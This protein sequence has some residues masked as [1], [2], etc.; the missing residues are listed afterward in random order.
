MEQRA[1]TSISKFKAWRNWCEENKKSKF[2]VRKEALV[3]KIWYTRQERLLKQVFD[4]LKYSAV[5]EK[6]ERTKAELDKDVP[7]RLELEQKKETLIKVGKT[8]DKHHC[9]R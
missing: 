7:I 9:L 5:N 3:D 6:Y 8:R 1:E 4:A 2:F